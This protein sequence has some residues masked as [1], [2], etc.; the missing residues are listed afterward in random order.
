MAMELPSTL[1]LDDVE[2]ILIPPGEFTMGEGDDTHQLYLEAFY[3][4]KYPITNA[5]YKRFVEATGHKA[6]DHWARG[7]IP[8]GKDDHPVVNVSWY[9]ARAY[10]QWLEDE[11]AYVVRLPTEAG[12]EKAAR[13]TDG[14]E[15]PW[16]DE[17]DKD[18]CNT[19]KSGIWD[20]TPVAKYSP[21][22]DSPYGVADMAGNVWEWTGSLYKDYPYDANDGREDLEEVGAR[23]VRG[24]AFYRNLRFVRC[25][26][27]DWNLPNLRSDHFGFRAAASP[28]PPE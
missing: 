11:T 6:P 24:G 17:F 23:V 7:S 12:W 8:A 10:C 1:I 16:G 27:R 4:A 20:T 9:D 25:A 15:Y 13:G 28:R 5:Q 18:R 26:C 3:I 21:Q 14:R 2:L 19:E 22:G